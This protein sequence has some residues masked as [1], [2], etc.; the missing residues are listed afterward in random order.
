MTK[1]LTT[2]AVCL[3][4]LCAGMARAQATAQEQCDYQRISAWRSYSS[5]IEGVVAKDAK[6]IIFDEFAAF[7]RC[8]HTYFK[9]WTVF[10][11][12][13]SLAGSTCTGS[14]FTNNGDQTVTD[15]LSGLV[16]EKK[17]NLDGTENYADPHDADNAYA[18][19]FGVKENGDVFISFLRL[20]NESAGFAGSNGWRLPTLLE[21]QSIILDF[22]CRGYGGGPLC[23]C[24]SFP[25]V[26][27]ALDASN[28]KPDYYWS[29]TTEV[30]SPDYALIVDFGNGVVFDNQKSAGS[31]TR[32]VRGGL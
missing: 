20:I 17:D 10:Q 2:V 15:N 9:N 8:R 18:W 4:L 26:D 19:G 7:A 6:G 23:I 32:A 5:C 30:A 16:W 3:T 31:G 24:P 28:T 11:S 1:T 29:A 21:L 22:A 12:R 25:C 13:A 14:R 27:P